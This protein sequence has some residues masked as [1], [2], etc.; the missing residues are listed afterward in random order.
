M[1][2]QQ[3][4]L[5]PVLQVEY[6]LNNS[7]RSSTD[8]LHLLVQR[9]RWRRTMVRP[10]EHLSAEVILFHECGVAE[11]TAQWMVTESVLTSVT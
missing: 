9:L 10:L 4:M 8:C 3:Y 2:S 6:L 1:E 11:K 7:S 5:F